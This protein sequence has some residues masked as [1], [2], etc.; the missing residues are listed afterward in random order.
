MES[1]VGLIAI[2]IVIVATMFFVL[3]RFFRQ[4]QSDLKA[5]NLALTTVT[6]ILSCVI[7]T[8]FIALFFKKIDTIEQVGSAD[9]WI[10]FA[11][12]GMSGV[13]TM[14]VLYFTLKPSI[15]AN[16]LSEKLME[17]EEDR[18]KL[19]MRPFAFVSN[20]TAFEIPQKEL[21]DDPN[22]KYIQI[23]EY[24]KGNA[25]GI[26]LELTNTTQSCIAV[27]YSC[28]QSQNG[29]NKW[30]YAAVNQENLKMTLPSGEKDRFVFYA[31]PEFM[32]KQLHDRITVELS[33]ENRFAERY[34]ETFELII[35]SLANNVS[36][37]PGKWHC[38]LFVQNYTIW[39]SKIKES[40]K[41]EWVKETLSEI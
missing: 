39:R 35:T 4:F 20:W 2:I 33:L 14:L 29:S 8:Y 21:I 26:A 30:G 34:K 27:S 13:I 12:A 3:V 25:L 32:T 28:G 38:H 41:I 23:G 7:G 36:S 5:E 10:G 22:E 18:Y 19:E 11:G 6:V 9:A 17:M 24:Q 1:L 31:S 16:E 37:T 15:K 40:G